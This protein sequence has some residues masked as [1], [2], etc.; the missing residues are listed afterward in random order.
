MTND[1]SRGTAEMTAA[2]LISGTIGWFVIMSGQ[3]VLAVVFWRCLFGA[4]ALLAVCTAL[5]LVNR[6]AMSAR[7]LALAS[8]GGVAIVLNW[9]LLFKAYA[10]TSISVAT[11]VYNTQPFMLL[12][13]GTV[14]LG[15]RITSNKIAWLGV[16]F[17]G[18][19]FIVLVPGS[20]KGGQ[21]TYIIGIALSL[22]AAFLYAVA[23]LVTKRLR[24]TPPH[25]I[26]LVQVTTGIIILAPLADFSVLPSDASSWGMLATLGV[27]HTGLMYYL[28]YGA[29]QRL[30]THI[31]GALSFIYPAAAVG[32]DMAAFGHV[33]RPMQYFGAVLILAA[34]AGMTLGWQL[35]PM[36]GRDTL[37]K[38]AKG[39]SS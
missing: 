17:L 22:S 29:I 4:L 16:S 2:M 6:K 8:F 39:P 32:V 31:T 3:P 12:A 28:L 37:R 7:T 21:G 25:L 33:L 14:F 23:S 26:A 27:A 18:M 34:A 30:P 10:L 36:G 24:G 11:I 15:D 1:I 19:I 38:P 9:L 20:L 5:G 13:L 35:A